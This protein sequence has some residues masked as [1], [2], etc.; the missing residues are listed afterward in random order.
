M[1]RSCHSMR[2]VTHTT[3]G[4]TT[5][6]DRKSIGHSRSFDNRTMM[7][8]SRSARCVV[9]ASPFEIEEDNLE[10][11]ADDMIYPDEFQDSQLMRMRRQSLQKDSSRRALLLNTGS[12]SVKKEKELPSK[13]DTKNLS[14]DNS[15]SSRSSGKSSNGSNSKHNKSKHSAGSS[16]STSRRS[17]QGRSGM[18]D[19]SR[20]SVSTA[21]TCPMEESQ[22]SLI[23][24]KS[25][26]S[27]TGSKRRSSSRR[28]LTAGV[29]AAAM[30]ASELADESIN[31][32]R[33]SLSNR[34]EATKQRSSSRK[35]IGKSGRSSSRRDLTRS[36]S[37][38]E[39]KEEVTVDESKTSRRSQS[40][41]RE[42]MMRSS[43]KREVNSSSLIP[44]SSM[45]LSEENSDNNLNSD[46]SMGMNQSS[47]H[48]RSSLSRRREGLGRTRSASRRSI[49]SSAS[50]QVTPSMRKSTMSSQSEQITPTMRRTLDESSRRSLS[51]RREALT[52]SASKRSMSSRKLLMEQQEEDVEQQ[53][54]DL[55]PKRRESAGSTASRRGSSSKQRKD[56]LVRGSSRR[57]MSTSKSSRKLLMEKD[58]KEHQETITS[59]QMENSSRR[60]LSKR[61]E[62]LTRAPSSRRS[63]SAGRSSRN[64]LIEQETEDLTINAEEDM[65][66]TIDDFAFE[67]NFDDITPA[68]IAMGIGSSSKMS[69]SKSEKLLTSSKIRRSLS[70][71]YDKDQKELQQ[72]CGELKVKPS[73]IT[74]KDFANW[75]DLQQNGGMN[76]ISPAG[77]KISPKT[78]P[79]RRDGLAKSISKRSM[80][81]GLTGLGL[82]R[83]QSYRGLGE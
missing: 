4:P 30:D 62:G 57:S 3:A 26:L 35:S 31:Q 32:S 50:E 77:A 66:T 18:K 75:E 43:S 5:T 48:T 58:E 11:N 73:T 70:E 80:R 36:S 16:T 69:R 60:S 17:K 42:G 9:E 19:A 24:R 23:S 74:A 28:D 34:R 79:N 65:A 82:M 83:Q 71:K 54:T 2:I 20:R 1:L 67:A 27:A 44:T 47:N 64:L 29:N 33:N 40:S 81:G 72:R 55:S 22:S 61:R 46:M 37:R 53:D 41:R 7:Q 38:R 10:V 59:K 68:A 45:D 14:P 8:R 76:K 51:K 63:M 25:L 52:R 12:S 39:V 15:L 78:P 6:P 13:E 21:S 56:G 49:M